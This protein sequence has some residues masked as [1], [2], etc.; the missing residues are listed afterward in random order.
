[1]GRAT[2]WQSTFAGANLTSSN[3]VLYRLQCGSGAA[4]KR[5][6]AEADR[7]DEVAFRRDMVAVFNK[8]L[9][10]Q[11]RPPSAVM[12]DRQQRFIEQVGAAG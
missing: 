8:R 1:M 5:R 11:G 6:E 12:L 9:E 4:A 3:D 10:A 2:L 7:A